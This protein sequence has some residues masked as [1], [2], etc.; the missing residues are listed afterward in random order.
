MTGVFSIKKDRHLK[1]VHSIWSFPFKP[2][3]SWKNDNAFK[4]HFFVEPGFQ[5]EYFHCSVSK[6]TFSVK[7]RRRCT[8]K[9]PV[10]T[11]EKKNRMQIPNP[12]ISYSVIK[13]LAHAL[14]AASKPQKRRKKGEEM[15]GAPRLQPW[16][17]HPFL[18][19]R[20]LYNLS[21]LKVYLDQNGGVAADLD[22]ISRVVLPKKVPIDKRMGS[23]ERQRLTINQDAL[24]QLK[25]LNK[26]LSRMVLYC[27][28]ICQKTDCFSCNHFEGVRDFIFA[29]VKSRNDLADVHVYLHLT[30]LIPQSAPSAQMINIQLRTESSVSAKE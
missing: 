17:F 13:I 21:L 3:K 28:L 10:E 19:K 1:H 29:N 30:W 4:R 9:A 20:E 15:L 11:Q 25:L 24:S 7:G 2:K 18:K 27:N 5:A 16:K 14:S 8:Q 12:A 26:N 6:H 23:F 22:I